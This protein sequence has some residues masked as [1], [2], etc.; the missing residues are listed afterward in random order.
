MMPLNAERIMQVKQYF[1]TV[2]CGLAWCAQGVVPHKKHHFDLELACGGGVM[3]GAASS[4]TDNDPVTNDPPQ[5][6][7][8]FGAYVYD[9][10]QN[11]GLPTGVST[12]VEMDRPIGYR[13]NWNQTTPQTNHIGFAGQINMHYAMQY[14]QWKG[15]VYVGV[16]LNANRCNT[17]I[18]TTFDTTVENNR[19]LFGIPNTPDAPS[20]AILHVGNY[21]PAELNDAPLFISAGISQSDVLEQSTRFTS[22]STPEQLAMVQ[23]MPSSK[24][25]V[26]SG[27][28]LQT[29]LRLGRMVGNFYPHVR[30]GYAA[31]QL[32]ASM[33]NQV[34][35]GQVSGI[36]NGFA[37][38]TYGTNEVT[39][40]QDGQLR[41][42]NREPKGFE[43]YVYVGCVN[44]IDNADIPPDQAAKNAGATD[45]LYQLNRVNLRA[46]SQWA[47]AVTLGAGIDWHIKK[48]A[49][50]ILYQAA[51]CQKVTFKQWDDT[52]TSGIVSSSVDFAG[53]EW[54]ATQNVLTDTGR[55]LVATYGEKNPEYSV[56]PVFH[57]VML[58]VKYCF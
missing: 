20:F 10:A 43:D 52:V 7:N 22:T 1:M 30:V 2:L 5:M 57:T 48:W 26:T 51:I 46:K 14:N 42:M 49:L 53:E 25:T 11:Y 41:F 9:Y 55:R 21:T 34:R 45:G 40:K 29:G 54:N 47:N 19:F 31:Y 23:G 3:C 16:A 58:T 39:L 38:H 36:V 24:V 17:K 44:T 18:N 12:V 50:G 56:S 6:W 28:S 13:A 35:P 37:D 32:K 15:G 4:T 8:N 27:L 33:T